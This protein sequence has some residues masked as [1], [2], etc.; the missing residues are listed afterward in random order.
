MGASTRADSA[1]Q[2]TPGPQTTQVIFVRIVPVNT[3]PT[4][5]IQK[6]VTL[7]SFFTTLALNG[8]LGGG[9][10]ATVTDL[11]TN[12][13]AGA[14]DEDVAQGLI[15]SVSG[16]TGLSGAG[17]NCADLFSALPTL[18]FVGYPQVL[19]TCACP[20]MLKRLILLMCA[21]THQT[22]VCVI[23]G[24][25][26]CVNY[27]AKPRCGPQKCEESDLLWAADV[28]VDDRGAAAQCHGHMHR[29]HHFVRDAR[30]G[31]GAAERDSQ[32][33]DPTLPAVAC[34]AWPQADL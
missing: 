10:A 14:P 7:P 1:V 23:R 19:L 15:L 13:S 32:D 16:T 2:A 8:A 30:D 17:I 12:I 11:V 22:H 9:K 33:L 18:S 3:V 4:L 27:M 34:S 20:C 31:G 28:S 24:K 29:G 5:E 21:C 6:N 26:V 25:H